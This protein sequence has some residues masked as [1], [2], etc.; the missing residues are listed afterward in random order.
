MIIINILRLMRASWSEARKQHALA[1]R[2][3]PN[4]CWED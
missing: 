3:Y 2:R 1:R 4:L